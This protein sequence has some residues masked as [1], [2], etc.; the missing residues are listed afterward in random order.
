MIFL[1]LNLLAKQLDTWT[2]N[3]NGDYEQGLWTSTVD[4]DC[5]C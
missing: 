3:V 4:I 1:E 5:E 2:V